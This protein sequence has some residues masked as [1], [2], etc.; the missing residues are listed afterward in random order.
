VSEYKVDASDPGKAAAVNWATAV[1]YARTVA[2][3]DY[4]ADRLRNGYSIGYEPGNFE[5]EILFAHAAIGAV[6]EGKHG[7]R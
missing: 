7:E 5:A 4:N 1:L 3:H 6:G 2:M